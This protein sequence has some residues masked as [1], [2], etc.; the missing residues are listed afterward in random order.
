MTS[1]A[2]LLMML[3]FFQVFTVRG[4]FCET[5][6]LFR[7]ENNNTKLSVW[8]NLQYAEKL[9]DLHR[10]GFV[11]SRN[12][13]ALYYFAWNFGPFQAK[14][15]RAALDMVPP[16]ARKNFLW[17]ANSPPEYHLMRSVFNDSLVLFSPYNALL[18]E[19]SFTLPSIERL[20][21]P[22]PEEPLCLINSQGEPWKNHILSKNIP[23]KVFLTYNRSPAVDL[24]SLKP[25]AIYEQVDELEVQ[26]QLH[27]A[28]Y[29]AI[30][31]VEEGNCRASNEYLMAGLPVLSTYSIGGREIFYDQDNSILC[32]A[33]IEA[34]TD[35]HNRMKELLK[36]ANRVQIR[37]RAVAKMREFRKVLIDRVAL[38]FAQAGVLEDANEIVLQ[39]I[40]SGR[41]GETFLNAWGEHKLTGEKII[42]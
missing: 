22:V 20:R 3:S 10:L 12:A 31:S 21:E 30:F 9:A 26:K 29:G 16:A 13:Y 1:A 6:Y 27:L 42:A 33:T 5:C 23:R 7:T 15:Y 39:Q 41:Y 32:N 35:G 36:R 24:E 4:T 37:D 28:D 11:D 40:Y 25:L 14:R 17:L 19:Y 38:W 8:K 2:L 34:V 18:N